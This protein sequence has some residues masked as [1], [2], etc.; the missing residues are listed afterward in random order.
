[1]NKLNE[2]ISC[3]LEKHNLTLREFA[4]NCSLSHSYIAKLKNGIDPRSKSEIHPT[5]DT[6]SKLSSAMN[7][8]VKELLLQAGYI[9][10]AEN[11]ILLEDQIPLELRKIGIEYLELA[12]EMQDKN[13][14]PQD[15]KKIISAFKEEDK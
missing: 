11:H 14:S 13:I 9:D 6:I 12:K 7:I 3:Y 15:I 10:K 1:M 8:E 2:I 5:M 4:D